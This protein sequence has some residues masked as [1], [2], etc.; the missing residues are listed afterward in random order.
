MAFNVEISP[1]DEKL[2][3]DILDKGISDLKVSK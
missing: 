1:D 3:N 2:L